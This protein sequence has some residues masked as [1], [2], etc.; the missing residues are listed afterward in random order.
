MRIAIDCRLFADPLAEELFFGAAILPALLELP[1]AHHFLLVFDRAPTADWSRYANATVLVL[2]PKAETAATRALWYDL[3]LPNLLATHKADIFLGAAGYLSLRSTMKQ[4]ILLH[5]ALS[6]KKSPGFTGWSGSWYKR[7]L[8]AMLEKSDCCLIPATALLKPLHKK[9]GAGTCHI[10]PSFP[11]WPRGFSPENVDREG[12]KGLHADGVE[13]FFCMEG[14]QSLEDALALLLAFSAFKKRQQTG[15][16]LLLHGMPPREKAWQEK[17]QT[18]RYREDVVLIN[19]RTDPKQLYEVFCSAY[20]L[21]HLPKEPQLG[22]LQQAMAADVPVITAPKSA[23]K[24]MAGDAVFYCTDAPGE[25]LAHHMMRL[26]KD[27]RLRAD[28]IAKGKQKA[29]AWEPSG[30]ASKLLGICL[31]TI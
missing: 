17:L 2:K 15:M 9:P 18:F 14:W 7:R 23:I 3:R 22:T 6:G 21:I 30:I 28:L 20:G 8:P 16:K 12:V 5:D 10:L 11:L 1:G 27:E 31:G 4:I 26:Y 13:Y 25:S 19:E 29:A 24:E